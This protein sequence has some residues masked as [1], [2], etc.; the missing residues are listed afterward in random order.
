MR[1]VNRVER[2]TIPVDT[3]CIISTSSKGDQSKWNVG[4]KRIGVYQ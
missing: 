3:V 2:I 1:D 4:D